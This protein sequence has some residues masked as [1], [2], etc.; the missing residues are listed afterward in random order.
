MLERCC[1]QNKNGKNTKT[2]QEAMG[3]FVHFLCKKNT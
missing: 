1:G 3:P 2:K